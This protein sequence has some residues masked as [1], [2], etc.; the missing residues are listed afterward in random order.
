MYK[1]NED[2]TSVVFG[3]VWLAL[4]AFRKSAGVCYA[5]LSGLLGDIIAVCS[6]CQY[7][8]EFLVYTGNKLASTQLQK[9]LR[10]FFCCEI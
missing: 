2:N 7:L 5:S 10:E 8:Q 4:C 3:S 9:V 1:V 6:Y